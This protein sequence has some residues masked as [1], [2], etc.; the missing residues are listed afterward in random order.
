MVLFGKG[1]PVN[2]FI[3]GPF[4]RPATRPLKL[5]L[6]LRCRRHQKLLRVGLGFPVSLI[7]DEEKRFV[8]SV[9]QLGDA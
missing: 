2:G 5:P 9:V 8:S 3:T 4:P 1:V 7:I 6:S